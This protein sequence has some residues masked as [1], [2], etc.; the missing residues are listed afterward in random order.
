MGFMVGIQQ[1]KLTERTINGHSKK[2]AVDCWFT[3]EGRT[4]PRFVKYEDEDGC[5]QTLNDIEIIKSDQMMYAGII[6]QRFDCRVVQNG[7]IREFILLFHP[8]KNIWDMIV[9]EDP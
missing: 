2:V 3:S 6:A 7:K 4:I 9:R 5:I 1:E 8:D